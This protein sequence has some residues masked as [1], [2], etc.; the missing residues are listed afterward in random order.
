MANDGPL[1]IFSF[2]MTVHPLR[3]RHLSIL[4]VIFNK[5]RYLDRSLSSIFRLP[6]P[7]AQ[8]EVVCVN[9]G[10]TDNSTLVVSLY[11]QQESNLHLY[12]L[13][14]NMGTNVARLTAVRLAQTPYLTFLDPD[15]EFI[16]DGLRFALEKIIKH[17]AD[18]VEFGCY[19]R[20]HNATMKKCWMPPRVR[21]ATRDKLANLFYRARINCHVHR[22]IFRTQLYKDAVAAMPE[23]VTKAR[24]LRYEDKLHFAFILDKMRRMYYYIPKVGELRY[25]GLEDNSQSENYQSINDTLKNLNYVNEMINKTFHRWAK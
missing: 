20:T 25:W 19:T 2:G 9:D 7:R 6:I 21:E 17:D 3:A 10:S 12:S 14:P 4:M 13:T 1:P 15:D 5:G 18:I 11:Q 16:G 8:F 23:N 22:K 24:I